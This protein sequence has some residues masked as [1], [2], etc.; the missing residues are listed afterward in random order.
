MGYVVIA[1]VGDNLKALF[2]G[3]KEF[4]TQKVILIATKENL[5]AASRLGKKLEEFTIKY[6]II[7]ISQ[8][9][10][11]EMFRVFGKICSSYNNDELIV[12][13][14]TGDRMGTCAA[15]SASYANGLKTF[16]I[17]N[18][19]AMILPIMKL[20]YYNELSENKLKILSEI[21]TNTYTSL[22]DLSARLR[23]SISLLSYHINGNYKHKGL[24]EF[25]LVEL[26]EQ[27]KNLLVKLSEIGDLLLKGY[28]K[29]GVK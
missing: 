11:G 23:M 15:L 17:M 24:K 6:E 26:K 1:P 19:K 2:I 28:I 8:D 10:M 12:N 16:G 20:S 22:K 3:M 9:I 5:N 4:P 7:E 29:C 27:N 13:I 25:R 21:N 18:D 14:A